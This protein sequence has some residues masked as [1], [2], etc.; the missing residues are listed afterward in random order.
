[1]VF[2]R[3][4]PMSEPQDG[5]VIPVILAGGQGTRLWPLSR[6][7]HPKQFL[8]L[9][10]DATLLQECLLRVANDTLYALPLTVTHEDYRFL[11]AEQA[12]AIGIEPAGILLEPIARNTAAAIAAGTAQ[13]RK[14]NPDAIVQVLPSDHAI[15][16]DPSYA[17]AV[18]RG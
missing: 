1:M 18:L 9:N 7:E 14:D 3:N 4:C 15:G 2:R 12:R 16:A 10:S 11:V 17:E 5:R 6:S 13:A 8:A